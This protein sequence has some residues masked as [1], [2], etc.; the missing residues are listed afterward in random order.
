MISRILT[1]IVL[2]IPAVYLIGWSPQ[3]LYLLALL[4]IVERCLVEYFAVLRQGGFACLPLTGYLLGALV[5]LAQTLQIHIRQSVVLPVIALAL[6]AILIVAMFKVT[7]LRQYPT[8]VAST[9]LGI[10]YVGFA[11]SCLLPL[12]FGMQ[13]DSPSG[14]PNLVF[15]LFLIIWAGDIFAYFTGRAIGR[16]PFF[17]RISPKKTVEGAMGGLAGSLLAGAIFARFFLRS[18]SWPALIGLCVGIAFAGQ[19]GDLAESAFKRGA[20]VK[21]SG[22]ILP[23]HGGLLDRIDSVLFG[24]PALWAAVGAMSLLKYR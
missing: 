19:M 14:G 9:F 10:I 18:L 23:G 6:L 15:F 21:D 4:L 2:L 17:Q 8:A 20:G 16:T 12:R 5:C 7:D 13:R 22:S 11:F 3:W 24:A 1:A